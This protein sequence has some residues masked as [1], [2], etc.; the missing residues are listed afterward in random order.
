M[1][2]IVKF[3]VMVDG[4]DHDAAYHVAL[5]ALSEV[6]AGAIHKPVATPLKTVIEVL[7]TD[8]DG[9]YVADTALIKNRQPDCN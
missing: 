5:A 8:A 2:Y 3:A 4:A 6:A 7:V 1:Q 9:N